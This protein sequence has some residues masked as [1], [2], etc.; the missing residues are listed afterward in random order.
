MS[1]L[2]AVSL[3]KKSGTIC[4]LADRLV[5]CKR[6]QRRVEECRLKSVEDREHSLAYC[7]VALLLH[8]CVVVELLELSFEKVVVGRYS[9]DG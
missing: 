3:R 2:L 4:E 6:Q 8:S 5:F 7:N 1:R 9:R